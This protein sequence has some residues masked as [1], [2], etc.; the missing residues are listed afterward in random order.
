VRIYVDIVLIR[1]GNAIAEVSYASFAVPLA[2]SVEA[3][4]ARAAANRL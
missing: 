2:A 3:H 4:I 1:R